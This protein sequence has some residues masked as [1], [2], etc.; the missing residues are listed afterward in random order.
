MAIKDLYKEVEKEK[1]N[2]VKPKVV[3]MEID[4]FIEEHKELIRV[5]REGTKEERLAMADKQEEELSEYN[6]EDEEEDDE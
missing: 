2:K 3:T 6:E 5:L 4:D 1:K